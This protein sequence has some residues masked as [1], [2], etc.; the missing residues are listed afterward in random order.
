MVSVQKVKITE[1]VSL[2]QEL[3]HGWL[4]FPMRITTDIPTLF[5]LGKPYS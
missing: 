5:H 1:S 3:V 2:R 4:Y